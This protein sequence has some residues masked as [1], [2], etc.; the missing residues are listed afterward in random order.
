MCSVNKVALHIININVKMN[1]DPYL[2]MHWITQ[3]LVVTVMIDIEMTL[4]R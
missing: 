1:F 4:M 3:L 2:I